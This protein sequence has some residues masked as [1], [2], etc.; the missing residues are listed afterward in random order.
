MNLRIGVR[1]RS[2]VCETEIIVVRAPKEDIDLRCGGHAL[3][4]PEA[5]QD[6]T[7]SLVREFS[8]GSLL[9]KRYTDG[10]ALEVLVVRPG[11]GELTLST[12]PLEVMDPRVLPSSD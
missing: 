4:S 9:G 7:L 12:T 11:A 6:P 2:Q 5:P 10:D 1:Y 3:V 8:A